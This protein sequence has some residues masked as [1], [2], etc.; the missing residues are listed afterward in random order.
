[1]TH[2]LAAER[3]ELFDAVAVSSG[4]IG[5]TALVIEPTKP[6]PI[7]LMH[8]KNDRVVPYRGGSGKTDPDFRWLGFAHT[9]DVWKS[10]N[11]DVAQTN[12]ISYDDN[13]HEWDGWRIAKFWRRAPAASVE[14]VSFFRSI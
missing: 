13:G 3:P 1:M 10:I 7:L 4:S 11:G 12:V 9:C 8:G 14:V 6:M 5:S 2:R